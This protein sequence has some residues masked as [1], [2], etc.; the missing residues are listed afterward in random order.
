MRHRTALIVPALVLLAGCPPSTYRLGVRA[1]NDGQFYEASKLWIQALDED[2][3]QTKP[4]TKLEE[5]GPLAWEERRA[6][7]QEHEASGRYAEAAA[8][9]EDLF[10]FGEDLESVEQLSFDTSETR[11]E[12]EDCLASW[13]K[14]ELAKAVAA[15]EAAKWAEAEAHFDQVRELDASYPELDDKQGFSYLLWAQDDLAR[16]RYDDASLHYRKSFELTQSEHAGAWASAV[17]IAL[18]RYAL[19]KGK[20]RTAVGYFERGGDILGDSELEADRARA[21]DCA[22][23]GIVVEPVTEEVELKHGETA[24]ASMLVDLLERQ[25]DREGSRFVKLLA[26][27]V[28][29]E[30]ENAPKHRI[31]VTGRITQAVVEEPGTTEQKRTVEGRMSVECD[32][33]T[34]LYEPDAVCTDPVDVEYTHHRTAVAVRMGGSVKI[35]DLASGEQKT[36]PLDMTLSHDT[37]H[38]TDFRVFQEGTWVPTEVAVEAELGRVAVSEEVLALDRKPLP[39]PPES[40]L[41]RDA[42]N[43][44]AEAAGDAVLEEVDREDPPPPPKRLVVKEPKLLPQDLT[45]APPPK[46]EPEPE[47]EPEA[48]ATQ[49]PWSPAW[50]AEE[51]KAQRA[52]LVASLDAEDTAEDVPTLL[53]LAELALW[54]APAELEGYAERVEVFSPEDRKVAVFRIAL[55][56]RMGLHDQASERFLAWL[57]A[58][59]DDGLAWKYYGLL[60]AEQKSPKA[61]Q[62]LENAQRL[63]YADD[64]VK[65]NLEMVYALESRPPPAPV[66]EKTP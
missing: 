16:Y 28:I 50:R 41:V 52:E 38:A 7:A 65:N 40:D 66:P 2:I 64:Y 26:A 6:L 32:K 57:D 39:L 59:P 62:A 1:A 61:R 55:R 49:G 37:T 54:E 17:D 47:P 18:G 63:G 9:Y 45:F 42:V 11:R 30:V 48:P 25:I 22:R 43:V 31:R 21:E 8:V 4:S 56:F 44:L 3:Y 24:L 29:G 20:C 27:D 14:D 33:E 46:P 12:Y 34:L 60:L 53:K 23:I 58:R 15:D 36:R 13:A 19:D 51:R 10:V 35:V 5:Y